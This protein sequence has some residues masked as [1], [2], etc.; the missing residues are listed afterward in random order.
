MRS[1]FITSLR[2]LWRRVWRTPALVTPHH[3]VKVLRQLRGRHLPKIRQ[4]RHFSKL[5]TPVEQRWYRAAGVIFILGVVWLGVSITWQ[6]RVTEPVVGGEYVEGV[7][8]SPRAINPLFAPLNEVDMDL[9]RLVYSGLMRYDGAGRLVPDLAASYEVSADKKTYQFALRKGA[10][11]QDSE[12]LTARDVAFTVEAIQDATV[13]SPLAPS[14]QDVRVNVVDDYTVQFILSTSAPVFL[15]VLTVGILPEHVWGSLPH[16]QLRLAPA[17]LVKPIGSGPYMVKRLYKDDTGYIYRYSLTR[18]PSYYGQ[19]PY[20][21]DLTFQF[22]SDYDGDQGAIQALRERK[23]D[24]LNFVPAAFREQATRKHTQLYTLQLPQYTAVFFNQDRNADLADKEIRVALAEAL[25]KERI[26]QQA[27]GGEGT[28]LS[29]PVLPGFPGYDSTVGVTTSSVEMASALLDKK[30][31]RLPVDEY[32]ELLRK[33][34]RAERQASETS[35]TTSTPEN[36]STSTIATP[37]NNLSEAE[38]E[39]L[40][41]AELNDSQLFYRQAKDGH[42]LEIDLVTA[43]TFEYRQTVQLI[44]GYWQELGVKVNITYVSPKDMSRAVLKDRVYDALLYGI[45]VGGDP[46]QSPFWH[47]SEVDYP[48]LNLARYQNKKVD[49][50]LVKMR[51]TTDEAM[52][53]SLYQQFDRAI[54]SDLPAI[55]LFAPTYTYAQS[56][57]LKGFA[58]THIAHPSDRFANVTEWYIKT[59]GRFK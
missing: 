26:L 16:D 10:L 55:F 45:I 4:W 8:G 22:F 54:R 6:Y 41:Q 43:D 40:V 50:I 23:I 31:K 39:Q 15:S 25:D 51:T 18:F 13:G 17:N 52:V 44:A 7:I 5:L 48:G 46:D 2:T 11:W 53:A 59:G 34:F 42:V 1:R 19:T 57:K 32:K 27:V 9:T 35:V 33:K 29:G 58:V 21:Q 14:F 38:V 12:P 47:S 56:D 28:M 49:E 3:D 20:V 30:W 36:A 24:G 37:N